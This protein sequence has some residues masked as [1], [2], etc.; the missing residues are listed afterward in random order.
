MRYVS[1]I[2]NFEKY[3]QV[4]PDYGQ[5]GSEQMPEETGT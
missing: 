4:N 5:Y 1:I 3:L 2:S